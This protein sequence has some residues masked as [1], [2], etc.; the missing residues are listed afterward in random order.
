MPG[1]DLVQ[2]EHHSMETTENL[3]YLSPRDETVQAQQHYSYGLDHEDY[4]C[5]SGC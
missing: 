5:G 1:A 4:Y 2:I 3:D